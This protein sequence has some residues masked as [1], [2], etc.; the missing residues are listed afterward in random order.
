[1]AAAAY[2]KNEGL[3]FAG[4]CCGWLILGHTGRWAGILRRF[5]LP[6][7][8]LYAPWLLWTRFVLRLGSH[9]VPGFLGGGAALGRAVDR[10]PAALQS[11]GAMWMDVR[12][13]NVVVWGVLFLSL[14]RL[15]ESSLRRTPLLV[16][17]AAVLCFFVI[18]VFH[19][20]EIWLLMSSWNRLTAQTLPILILAL[21]AE[22]H[23][24]G[25]TA[26]DVAPTCCR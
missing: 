4:L 20:Q 8:L 13:W 1:L 11:V 17:C 23:R 12:Q 25:V 24:E 16:P 19:E 26:A 22:R 18:N 7:G 2:T 14:Y 9:V 15:F 6:L 10:L 3:F 21:A 5:V